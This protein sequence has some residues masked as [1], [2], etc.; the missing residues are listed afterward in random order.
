MADFA[1]VNGKAV[2]ETSRSQVFII[3]LFHHRVSQ[4]HLSELI[5]KDIFMGVEDKALLTSM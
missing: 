1:S 3:F 4:N 2:V 5:M